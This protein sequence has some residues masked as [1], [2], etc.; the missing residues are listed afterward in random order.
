MISQFIPPPNLDTTDVSE[1]YPISVII[2][3]EEFAAID[4]KSFAN[5]END[6]ER[7]NL[8]PFRSSRWIEGKMRVALKMPFGPKKECL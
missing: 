5:A 8:L 1:V 6:R 7:M 2:P 3:P 4:V